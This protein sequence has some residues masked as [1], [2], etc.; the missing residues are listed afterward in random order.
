MIDRSGHARGLVRRP[1]RGSPTRLGEAPGVAREPVWRRDPAPLP[2]L[3]CPQLVA[4]SIRG[5]PS[6]Q[7]PWRVS[8][9]S[10]RPISRVSMSDSTCPTGGHENA[11]HCSGFALLWQASSPLVRRAHPKPRSRTS[12]TTPHPPATTSEP[13]AGAEASAGQS[14]TEDGSGS[15][16]IEGGSAEAQSE[17]TDPP[18][19]DSPTGDTEQRDPSGTEQTAA[20]VP[21]RTAVV[22]DAITLAGFDDGV[23]V[24]VELLE[25]VDPAESGNEFVQPE[26][27][28]RY[29][30]VRLRLTNVGEAVYE[31]SPSNGATVIDTDDQQFAASFS[32]A[33][34]PGLGTLTIKQGDRRAGFITVEIPKNAK[35]R[36][37]KVRPRQRLRPRNRRMVAPISKLTEG[38]CET[39]EV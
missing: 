8:I 3:R 15:E 32:D 29:V 20:E 12:R 9:A 36:T 17:A 25:V 38:T 35:L 1:G 23:S 27:G 2:V 11:C 30:A 39:L 22:G 6:L 4:C 34:E 18:A 14:A 33:V 28:N 7:L 37:F 21:S 10:P 13:E 19:P 5:V 26:Q 16:E 24:R 31:D